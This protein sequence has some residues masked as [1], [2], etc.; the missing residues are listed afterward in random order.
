MQTVQPKH[1][2]KGRFLCLPKCIHTLPCLELQQSCIFLLLLILTNNI[3][4]HHL[5]TTEAKSLAGSGN[6]SLSIMNRRLLSLFLFFSFFF[7]KGL[8]EPNKLEYKSKI[9]Q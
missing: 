3:K 1:L 7:G 9:W 2:P 6:K 8:L 5:R 4:A